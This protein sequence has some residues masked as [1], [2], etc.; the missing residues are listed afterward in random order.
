MATT[1]DISRSFTLRF[2]RIIFPLASP[3]AA[4]RQAT[5]ASPSA[6]ARQSSARSC[7]GHDV[8]EPPRHDD[9]LGDLAAVEPGTHLLVGE[10]L[11]LHV[12]LGGGHV[13]RHA[14][15]HLAVD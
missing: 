11:V 5:A 9:D 15:P 6:A 14:A 1:A 8:D 10:G 12:A 7:S 4:A 2:F 13:H 3:S